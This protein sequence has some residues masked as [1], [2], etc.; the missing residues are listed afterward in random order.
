MYVHVNRFAICATVAFA[1]RRVIGVPPRTASARA[2]VLSLP[3]AAASPGPSA[4]GDYSI[5]P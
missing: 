3:P 5:N 2:P 4:V 1:R